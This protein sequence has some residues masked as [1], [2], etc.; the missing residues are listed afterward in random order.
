MIGNFDRCD[1]LVLIFDGFKDDR[2]PGETFATA[3]GVTE[4]TW[5]WAVDKKIVADKPID[6][7][8]A[9]DCIAV[10]KEFWK[11][12]GCDNW[13]SGVDLMVYNAAVL[14]GIGHA[15]RFLQRQLNVEDDGIIGPH[16]IAAEKAKDPAVL[17]EDLY[18]ADEEYLASLANA[19]LDL[20]GWLRRE[21]YMRA[22]ARMMLGA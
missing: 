19:P 22:H 12:A 4:Y 18:H 10:R 13:A 2:A 15:V 8:T 1:K 9:D 21:D 7:A 6:Q 5:M 14:S 20:H 17:I 3:Y 11:E 16:T